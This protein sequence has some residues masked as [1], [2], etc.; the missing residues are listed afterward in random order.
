MIKQFDVER[1]WEGESQAKGSLITRGETLRDVKEVTP[2]TQG[3]RRMKEGLR[4]EGK[5]EGVNRKGGNRRTCEKMSAP[6]CGRRSGSQCAS[7][8]SEEEKSKVKKGKKEN[9]FFF[10]K[11]PKKN[12]LKNPNK[13]II[14]LVRNFLETSFLAGFFFFSSFLLLSRHTT[15]PSSPSLPFNY[16]ALTI[17]LPFLFFFLL[18]LFFLHFRKRKKSFQGSFLP[19][20]PSSSSW[21]TS[22]SFFFFCRPRFFD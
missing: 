19:P 3:Q 9:P 8:K 22:F 5:E 1:G 12:L 20:L 7:R 14:L 18:L 10:Q 4:S 21:S 17:K 2:A 16:D 6:R 13:I 11:R 15:F